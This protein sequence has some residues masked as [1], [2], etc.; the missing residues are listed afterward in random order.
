M[1]IYNYNNNVKH[2][3]YNTCMTTRNEL[4]KYIDNVRY[5]I[6]VHDAYE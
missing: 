2:V 5:T 6:S 3:D 1:V 4:Y